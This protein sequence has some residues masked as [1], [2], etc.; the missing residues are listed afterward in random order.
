MKIIDSHVH[1]DNVAFPN[2]IDAKNDLL[3][4]LHLSRIEFAFLLH[5]DWQGWSKHEFYNQF[6]SN[7]KI[8]QFVNIDANTTNI[9]GDLKEAFHDL[10]YWGLKLHPRFH[11]FSVNNPNVYEMSKFAGQLGK[12]ILI[13]VFP[14]ETFLKLRL[15][16]LDFY[17]LAKENPDTNFIWAHFGG[18][19]ILDYLML[20]RKLNNVYFDISFSLL[21]Y[22][23]SSVLKDII[24]A[25]DNIKYERVLYGSDFPD[26]PIEETLDMTLEIL[27]SY[28]ISE[29]DKLKLFHT[30]A[31][32]LIEKSK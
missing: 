21:Y 23:K 6:S 8:Y 16:P 9:S 1:L 30:N 5:L 10:E 26:R 28:E 14:D 24:F 13:D 12:P 15:E 31:V 7:N 19:K 25:L 3:Q 27:D 2:L 22:R 17:I 29:S 4:Q 20:G 11:N 32:D 18:H